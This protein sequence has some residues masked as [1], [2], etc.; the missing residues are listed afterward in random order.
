M[1]PEKVRV[2][3]VHSTPSGAFRPG[4]YIVARQTC[5]KRR[6]IGTSDLR[7]LRKAGVIAEDKSA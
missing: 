5:V 3:K 4:V 1:K 7:S 2:T 6:E